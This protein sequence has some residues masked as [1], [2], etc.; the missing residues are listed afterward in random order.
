MIHRTGPVSNLDWTVFVSLFLCGLE[1][2]WSERSAC[3]SA[4]KWPLN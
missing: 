2:C 4:T 1:E 3:A